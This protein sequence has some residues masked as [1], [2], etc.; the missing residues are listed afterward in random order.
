MQPPDGGDGGR[1]PHS[2][3]A[4]ALLFFSDRI[5]YDGYM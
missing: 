4:Y 5:L 3:R 2:G 1:R